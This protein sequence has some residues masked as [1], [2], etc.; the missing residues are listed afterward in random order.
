MSETLNKFD[1]PEIE[2][3]YIMKNK[4]IEKFAECAALAYKE[5]PLFKYLTNGKCQ[6]EVIK[7]IISASIKGMKNKVIGIA[8]EEDANAV[9]LFTP[10]NYKGTSPFSFLFGGGLKLAFL[11][12]PLIYFRLLKYENNAINIKEKYTKHKCWYLYNLTVK[13]NFQKNGMATKLLKPM[14]EYLDRI[15]E[16]CYLETHKEENVKIYEKFGFKLVEVS[17]IPK[18]ELTQY[19]M[20]RECKTNKKESKNE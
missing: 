13:P 14:L 19:S 6:H 7:T 16:D 10:P 1:I 12:S 4:D 20:L 5:Y 18:T 3:F 15:G 8:L 2:K 11:S 9:V 17:K